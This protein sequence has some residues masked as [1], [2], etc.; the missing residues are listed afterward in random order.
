MKDINNNNFNDICNNKYSILPILNITNNKLIG[1]NIKSEN[2][3]SHKWIFINKI[4]ELLILN[5]FNQYFE[6][7]IKSIYIEK[8]KLKKKG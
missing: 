4:I 7:D 2:K 6:T 8:M 1:I 5:E 3:N